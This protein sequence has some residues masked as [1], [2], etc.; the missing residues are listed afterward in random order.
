MQVT[1]NGGWVA[2][3]SR[4]GRFIYYTKSDAPP[5]GLWRMPVS[6]GEESLVIPSIAFRNF[7]VVNDGIYFI[8]YAGAPRAAIHNAREVLYPL[9]GLRH[10]QSEDHFPH[11]VVG[12]RFLCFAGRTVLPVGAK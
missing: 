8:E 9:S 7:E 3:E 12:L 5:T 4:D 2:F 1:R 11:S 10:G 6:G